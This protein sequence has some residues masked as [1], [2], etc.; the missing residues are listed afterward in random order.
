[1]ELLESVAVAFDVS[2]S[3]DQYCNGEKSDSKNWEARVNNWGSKGEKCD[4]D[5][6]HRWMKKD[7]TKKQG[8]LG[9]VTAF[10]DKPAAPGHKWQ[11]NKCDGATFPLQAHHII[12]KNHLP[13]HGVCAF[14]ASK[15]KDDPD[16][17]LLKDTRYDNDHANNGYCMPY[18]TPLHEWTRAKNEN[19]KIAVAYALMNSTGRQLHQG[20]HKAEAYEDPATAHE[21]ESIHA[22][23]PGYLST[24]DRFLDMVQSGARS[25]VATCPICKPEAGK[26][27]IQPLEAVVR[28]MDQVSGLVKLLIDANR[29]FVSKLAA[30]HWG[31]NRKIVPIPDWLIA[32]SK[33]D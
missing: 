18:A 5:R 27:K 33:K 7:R 19:E 11:L 13:D 1:M 20:S 21:D 32:A 29:I 28:H 30:W 23:V 6:L 12:P 14:L 22:S 9:G 8:Y 31:K 2:L 17:E 4:A 26:K 3:Q 16:F 10:V 25:H 24:V 15:C